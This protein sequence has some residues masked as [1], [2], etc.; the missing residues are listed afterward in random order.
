MIAIS[1]YRARYYDPATGRFL[2]EDP[3]QFA[4]GGNFFEYT[5]NNPQRFKDPSGL[6]PLPVGA[7]PPQTFTVITGGGGA[8]AGG[9]V[10]AATVGLAALDVGLAVYDGVQL[11]HL[12]QAYGWWENPTPS[13][14]PA[15]SGSGGGGCPKDPCDPSNF[16]NYAQSAASPLNSSGGISNAGSALQS[17]SGRG[18][19]FPA[20]KGPPAAWNDA[21]QTL[22]EEILTNPNSKCTQGHSPRQGDY[23]QI[24]LPNGI[25]ARWTL[26]GQWI[27]FIGR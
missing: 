1:H 25:G 9:G 22:V 4:G 27:G 12:G 13:Q 18:Q 2:S 10:I 7:P 6:Q 20:V 14:Q 21:A 17:H 16:D 15:P 5:Y 19:G 24:R 8:A 23:V 11:Y 3:L 26:T